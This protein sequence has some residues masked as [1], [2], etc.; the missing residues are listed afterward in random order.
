VQSGI[1]FESGHKSGHNHFRKWGI[2][3]VG[4]RGFEPPTPCTPCTP[5]RSTQLAFDLTPPSFDEA[6]P[7]DPPTPASFLLEA[8]DKARDFMP[9]LLRF[10]PD[11]PAGAQYAHAAIL[12][13]AILSTPR[14]EIH[15]PSFGCANP[16]GIGRKAGFYCSSASSDSRLLE[17]PSD[18]RRRSLSTG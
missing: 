7:G 13:R 3:L 16:S 12:A 9:H 14:R 8:L 15:A 1:F 18:Y 6:Y 11:A 5:C 2:S 17:I 10:F 4:A